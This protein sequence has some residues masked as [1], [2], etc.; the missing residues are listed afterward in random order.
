M[1]VLA[2]E[3]ATPG[4]V[5]VT[6][7]I[8]AKPITLTDNGSGLYTRHVHAVRH[9]RRLGQGVGERRLHHRVRG[10]PPARCAPDLSPQGVTKTL[11]TT[12]GSDALASFTELAGHTITVQ[13]GAASFGAMTVTIIGPDGAKLLLPA[14]LPAGGG[15]LKP[16]ATWLDGEYTVRVHPVGKG[17]GTVPI[18]ITDPNP[19][20][21]TGATI[22][23]D[24]TPTVTSLTTAGAT[25]AYTFQGTAGGRV[26]M[27]ITA[28]TISSTTVQILRPDGK[29]LASLANVTTA[30][31]YVNAKPLPL[32]GTYTLVIDPNGNATGS[33]TA[34]VWNLPPDV[35]G[36]LV[37]NDPGQVISLASPGQNAS[38]TFAGTAGTAVT[39]RLTADS[40]PGAAF[41][42]L[43]PDSSVLAGPKSFGLAGGKLPVT[44]PVNGTYTVVIDPATYHAGALTVQLTS[45]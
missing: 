44:L 41:T 38:L 30:G 8:G 9:R 5:T 35:T 12:A 15:T 29:N 21:D 20:A 37:V 3:C 7:M 31:A 33:L 24:G 32:T 22:T 13:V 40:I 1:R 26:S 2:G 43:K 23:P 4:G 10:R 16:Q 14:S 25:A 17:A 6:A 42:I 36:T 18:T 39:L 34:Q 27:R 11:T 45:P 19:P 28:D